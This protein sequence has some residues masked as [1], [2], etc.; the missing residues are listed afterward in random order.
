MIKPKMLK[1]VKVFKNGTD[2]IVIYKDRNYDMISIEVNE[3]CIIEG[4]SG[5]FYNG[6]HG[7]YDVPE[8]ND[9]VSLVGILKDYLKTEKVE[10]KE[11]HKTNGL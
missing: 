2:K 10:L 1:N 7:Y 6:C 11:Y 9:Y 3:K 8:Y 4:N 5:D